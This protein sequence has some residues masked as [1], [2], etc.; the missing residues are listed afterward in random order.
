[1][2][3]TYQPVERYRAIMALLFSLCLSSANAF[4]LDQFKFLSFGRGLT[5]KAPITT[6][7]A[8]VASLDQDKAVQNMQPNLGSTVSALVKLCRQ[9][10][11]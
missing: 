2:D 4:N 10:Q 8:F 11:Q 6:E 9:K 3:F 5:L 1:M 7:V